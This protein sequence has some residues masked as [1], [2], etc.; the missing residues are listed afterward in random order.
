[1][2]ANI[3]DIVK[4]FTYDNGVYLLVSSKNHPDFLYK[5]QGGNLSINYHLTCVFQ[6][7]PKLCPL[8]KL[9]RILLQHP[10][11]NIIFATYSSAAQYLTT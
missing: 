7:I 4:K 5:P 11:L 10:Q 3:V 6:A 2:A 9:L 1:M 8:P